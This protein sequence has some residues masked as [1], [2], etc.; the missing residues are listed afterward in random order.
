M[1]S[2][3]FRARTNLVA[4]NAFGTV[5]EV[6]LELPLV[7]EPIRQLQQTKPM[8]FIHPD[9]NAGSLF[10]SRKLYVDRNMEHTPHIVLPLALI[11]RSVAAFESPPSVSS[12]FLYKAGVICKN[13]LRP[14]VFKGQYIEQCG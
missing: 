1:R 11:D 3:G 8:P 13:C 5:H 14:Q 4:G 9:E 2:V 10:R 7:L 12:I 6:V